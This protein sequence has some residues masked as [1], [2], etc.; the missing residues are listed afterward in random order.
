MTDYSFLPWRDSPL[1]ARV[2]SLSRPHNHTQ[3][4]HTR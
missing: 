1:W 3:T 2:F 4:H